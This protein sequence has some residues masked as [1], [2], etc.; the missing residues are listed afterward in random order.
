MKSKR[1]IL[2]VL[3]AG[4]GDLILGSKAIRS[5]KNGS[6]ET[7]IHLLTST[8]AASVAENYEFLSK[9]WTFPIRELRK[10]NKYIF[11][12]LKILWTLRRIPF[13]KVVNLYRIG[14]MSGAIKMG[15][16]FLFLK[17]HIKIGHKAHGFGFFLT[18][19]VPPD[20]FMNRHFAES[21]LKIAVSAGAIPDDKGIEIFWD[22]SSENKWKHLLNGETPDHILIGINPGGDRK[23]RRWDTLRYAAVADQ[24]AER[25]DATIFLLGGPGEENITEQVRGNMKHDAVDLSGKLSL[26]DLAY[27][28]SRLDLLVTND[29]GPMHIGAA[30]QTPLVALFGPEDPKLMGPYTRQDLYRILYKDV[31]CR[32]CSQKR[33]E[34]FRCLDLITPQ[35]VFWKCIE[36]LE[37]NRPHLFK[38]IIP[39]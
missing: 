21:M 22:R 34:H 35:E 2:I 37:I 13:H 16:L 32:P 17:S 28:I 7:E 31:T 39:Q 29:S 25:F 23:N 14:S 38:K 18:K 3:I 27:I 9:V 12:M 30:T 26:N 15:F 19:T 8:V 33:C 20:T 5:I 6:P 11:E 10:N 24:L 4:I 1:Q 36:I